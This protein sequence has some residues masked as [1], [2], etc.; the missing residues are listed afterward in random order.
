MFYFTVQ[1]HNLNVDNVNI[2]T[3]SVNKWAE[4]VTKSPWRWNA[5]YIGHNAVK[6]LIIVT[7]STIIAKRLRTQDNLLNL[8]FV[9]NIVF[10]TDLPVTT[11]SFVVINTWQYCTLVLI[12]NLKN[13]FLNLEVLDVI[14][15]SRFLLPMYA[16]I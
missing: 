14:L 5:L 10:Q 9:W 1:C 4:N 12:T 7:E 11:S 3:T 15:L 6:Y 13:C 8:K 2:K 16:Q